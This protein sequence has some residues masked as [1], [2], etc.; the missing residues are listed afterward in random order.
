MNLSFLL[1]TV[2]LLWDAN[3][4]AT[5]FRPESIKETAWFQGHTLNVSNAVFTRDRR[6]MITVSHDRSARVWDLRKSTCVRV[7][8]EKSRTLQSLA[9]HP[10]QDMVAMGGVDTVIRIWS[11]KTATSNFEHYTTAI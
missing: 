10:D 6:T 2:V 11:L 4:R 1:T 5:L 7:V 8:M 9:L 3:A